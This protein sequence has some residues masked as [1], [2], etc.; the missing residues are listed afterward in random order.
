MTIGQV[1]RVLLARKWLFLGL[2][3][4]VALAGSAYTLTRPKVFVASASLV[5]DARPDPLLGALALPAS[6]ATQVMILKSDRVATRV[7]KIL[8]VE[9]SPEAVQQWR[10]A[11]NA[12]I[13]LDRY[14]A[15]ILGFGLVVESGVVVLLEGED[16][17][18]E[19]GDH[20]LEEAVVD[21][22]SVLSVHTLCKQAAVHSS[23]AEEGG[24]FSWG[25]AGVEV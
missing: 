5:V 12:K 13:P 21:S 1:L 14:F 20:R 11:T 19:G 8:G 10:E 6:M 16:E 9:R 24:L 7:V 4:L 2:F 17:P 22:G 23:G 15:E 18:G 3:V 25:L